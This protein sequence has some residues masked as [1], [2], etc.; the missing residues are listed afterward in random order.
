MAAAKAEAIHQVDS[1]FSLL[2]VILVFLIGTIVNQIRDYFPEATLP[3][4]TLFVTLISFSIL[5]GV[6]G[7]LRQSLF[8]KLCAWYC[9]FMMLF[10][11]AGDVFL[12][13]ASFLGH[14]QFPSWS[15]ITIPAALT[16]VACYFMT[17]HVVIDAYL[18]RLRDISC[19]D[20]NLEE[21]VRG[22]RKFFVFLTVAML[23][24]LILLGIEL[25][26]VKV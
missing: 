13:G 12:V 23:I 14:L 9:V 19:A 7:M 8:L 25:A 26:W 11:F 2:L 6:F 16:V 4:T 24:G 18:G 3:V 20:A 5:L 1:I 17:G 10:S 21:S 15:F 22:W